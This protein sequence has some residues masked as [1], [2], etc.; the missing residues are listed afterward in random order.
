VHQMEGG[1]EGMPVSKRI[2]IAENWN[3]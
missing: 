2:R 3:S 1:Y